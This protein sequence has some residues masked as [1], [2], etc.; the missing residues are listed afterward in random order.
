M[1]KKY[2]SYGHSI[3]VIHRHIA[4][5][6]NSEL[7]SEGLTYGYAVFLIAISRNSGCSQKDLCNQLMI[8]KTTTAKNIKK[9]ESMGYIWREKDKD[10][11]RFYHLYV[12]GK[13]EEVCVR[14]QKVL[15]QTTEILKQ[16]MTAEQQGEAEKLLKTME[17]NIC[18]QVCGEY[19][20]E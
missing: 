15:A 4:A 18:K 20:H 9:L 11:H 13:G 12:T 2:C 3:A 7:K 6:I 19:H 1:E 16:D 14:V 8:D 5:F 17:S 10:D